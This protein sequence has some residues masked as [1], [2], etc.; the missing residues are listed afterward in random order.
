M[1]G[2]IAPGSKVQIQVNREGQ[3]KMFDVELAEMSAGATEEGPETPPEESAQPEK[4][5]VF[6]G[7]AVA[8]ITDNVRSAL[9]LPKDVQGAR[10]RRN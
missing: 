1:I 8:D 6:G 9:N 3:T 2:S 4:T 10:D 7:F 5:T